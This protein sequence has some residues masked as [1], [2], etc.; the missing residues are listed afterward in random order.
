MEIAV[1]QSVHPPLTQIKPKCTRR[2][3]LSLTHSIDDH[4]GGRS[5][6][7][8]AATS[9]PPSFSTVVNYPAARVTPFLTLL[10]SWSRRRHH[11]PPSRRPPIL[12]CRLHVSLI[13]F[14]DSLLCSLFA[15]PYSVRCST[16]TV[17]FSLLF[18]IPSFL[19][20]S[21]NLHPFLCFYYSH[22]LF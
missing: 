22:L 14:S 15:A 2:S 9:L 13:V 6:L 1:T 11:Q 7:P 8:L 5:I 10:P 18:G 4:H 12:H 21:F 3:L 16:T 19:F 20:F 17:L